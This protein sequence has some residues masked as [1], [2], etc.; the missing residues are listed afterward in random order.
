MKVVSQKQM[1]LFPL[2]GDVLVIDVLVVVPSDVEGLPCCSCDPV[3]PVS[4][5]K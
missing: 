4:V 5:V 2:L 1:I 3:V